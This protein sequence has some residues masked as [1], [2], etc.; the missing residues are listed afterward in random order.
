MAAELVDRVANLVAA[1]RFLG[2]GAADPRSLRSNSYPAC[3]ILF[4]DLLLF[5]FECFWGMCGENS[6]N[7]FLL[8]LM[9]L[10]API[11]EMLSKREVPMLWNASLFL[12]LRPVGV[13]PPYF[14]PFDWFFPLL[15][16]AWNII[17]LHGRFLCR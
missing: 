8:L 10:W 12:G 2:M 17:Y 3:N 1:R 14:P 6:C 16:L 13:F 15:F 4:V 7:P 11:F 5:P 9:V